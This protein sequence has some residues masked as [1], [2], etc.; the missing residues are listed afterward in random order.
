M[1][2]KTEQG[3][4]GGNRGND[5]TFSS[6]FSLL[7]VFCPFNNSERQTQQRWSGLKVCVHVCVCV[8]V[9]VCEVFVFM[10][11]RTVLPFPDHLCYFLPVVFLCTSS[12]ACKYIGI[13]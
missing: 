6:L 10:S 2:E 1:E 11:L 5:C 8:C 12:V 4:L 3:R 9:C 13:H 7:F